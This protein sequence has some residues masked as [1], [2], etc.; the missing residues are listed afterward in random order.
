[1]QVA[2]EALFRQWAPLR[3]EV[4]TRAEA[5]KRR[6]ELDRWAADWTNSGRSPDY[7]LTGQRLVL[8]GQWLEAMTSAG[9]DSP[10]GRAL[11]DASRSH[12]TAFLH[13]V[14]ESI[15]GYALANVDRHPEL[16]I[17]LTA[18]A[19]TECPPTP[20]A[21]R[22]LMAALAFSHLDAV[23]AGHTDA[24]RGVAWSP[25]GQQVATA[26]R[27]GTARI[28]HADSTGREG[29]QESTGRAVRRYPTQAAQERGPD[30]PG[31]SPPALSGER[32]DQT[33]PGRPMRMVPAAG[34]GP[35][36]PPRPPTG[37]PRPARRAV[38]RMGAARR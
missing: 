26:S 8:A 38:A 35:T 23:L 11:L 6:T 3:Q 27:D 37:R 20:I 36:G 13:R 14:S 9:Q 2:H 10:A 16:A 29:E 15:G 18:S 1:M 12:D 22:A 5:L 33:A 24:V 32:A 4:A 30:R 25:D 34:H 7:L 28:W 19:L 21:R 17:L 31:F